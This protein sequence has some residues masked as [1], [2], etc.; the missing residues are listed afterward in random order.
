MT[1]WENVGTELQQNQRI[2]K[3]LTIMVVCQSNSVHM[4]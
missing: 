2:L 4:S 3:H 1:L